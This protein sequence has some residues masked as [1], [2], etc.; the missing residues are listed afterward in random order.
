MIIIGDNS[1]PYSDTFTTIKSI[2]E[3]KTTPPNSVVL[4]EFDIDILKYTYENN[5]SSAVL[6]TNIKQ[7]IYAHNLNTTYIIVEKNLAKTIQNIA[8]TYMFDSKIL[9]QIKHDDEIEEIALLGID[10]VIYLDN[11]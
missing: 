7:T 10:G 2:D 4:F 11:I 8:E 9:T 1:I 5:I 6:V 3:I